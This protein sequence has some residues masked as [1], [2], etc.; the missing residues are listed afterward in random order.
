MSGRK[1]RATVAMPDSSPPPPT[2]T[3]RVSISGCSEL[4]CPLVRLVEG[5]PVQQ[6][7]GTEAARALDLHRRGEFGHHDHGAQPKA[8]RVM[9]QAL[10]VVAG[11]G[12]DHAPDRLAAGHEARQLVQRPALLEGGCELQVLELQE[13]T[14]VQ[15]LAQGAALQAGRGQHLAGDLLRGGLH[16]AQGEGGVR[17]AVDPIWGLRPGLKPWPSGWRFRQQQRC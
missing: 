12:R 5:L 10:G 9:G 17:H 2:A 6:H 11:R 14:R 16:V 4:Q 8:L 1:A 3:T 15:D 7:L 13:D